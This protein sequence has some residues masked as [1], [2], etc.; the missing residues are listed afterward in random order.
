M[1]KNEFLK[2]VLL[3]VFISFSSNAWSYT[4]DIS[5]ISLDEVLAMEYE[6]DVPDESSQYDF[7]IGEWD[8]ELISY[9]EDGSKNSPL[10]GLWWAKYLHGKRVLFDDVVI[11]GE[12]G[13]LLAGYPSLRTFSKKL[14]KWV[15]MHMAPLE[16]QALCSNVG[17]WKNEE[18]HMRS[19]CRK[20]SGEIQGYSKI[21]FYDITED[22]FL[23]TW[24]ESKD[25]ENWRLYVTFEGKRRR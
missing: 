8:I 13:K 2:I 3:S 10:K 24:H 16:T 9:N 5:N 22:S 4:S 19:V 25:N 21:R 23:Y 1:T 15:S 12:S 18:M 6:G 7:L 14:G 20:T 11:F 17:T